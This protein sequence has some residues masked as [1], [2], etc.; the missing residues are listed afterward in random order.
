MFDPLHEPSFH[1]ELT[2]HAKPLPVLS[3]T[4]NEAINQPFEFLLDLHLDDCLLDTGSLLFRTAYFSFGAAGGGIHGLIQDL[5]PL[6]DPSTPGLWRLSLGPRLTCLARRSNQRLF[7][8][9]TVPQI[10]AQV[11]KEHG[12]GANLCRFELQGDY[13]TLELCTQYRETDLGFFQRLC[14][15]HG[16]HY[17]FHHQRDAHCLVLFDNWPEDCAAGSLWIDGEARH[18]VSLFEV[19][20]EGRGGW[21]RAR[22]EEAA[23]RAGGHLLVSGYAD[24]ASNGQWLISRVEHSGKP[25]APVP[26]HNQLWLRPWGTSLAPA[27]PLQKPRMPGVQRGRVVSVDGVHRDSRHRVA[28]Q[29]D[30][31]YQ[32]EGS[33]PSHCWLPISARRSAQALAGLVVGAEL[34]VSFIEDDPDRP[35][36]SGI[37]RSPTYPLDNRSAPEVPLLHL[38]ISRSAFMA[39]AP[40]VEVVGTGPALQERFRLGNSEVRFEPTQ[41]ILSSPRIHLQATPLNAVAEAEE[42][43][44]Q[45]HQDWLKQIQDS[46]PLTLLCLIP[47]GGSFSHCRQGACACR[48][49]AGPGLSG[50]A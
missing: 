20:V 48:M 3:F 25:V 42:G 32:G 7:S 34:C 27:Q 47:G 24:A 44:Q 13:P 21:A 45:E 29:F 49:V 36:I 22:T 14:E 43:T 39:Q 15:Q 46:Q 28:V 26:Y 33:A 50:A 8:E 38:Q 5:V 37:F 19:H 4:G 6:H 40:Q 17:H 31:L 10:L 18:A 2:G 41:V 16:I 12:I 11:L 1:L 23:V 30:W 9:C 35:L